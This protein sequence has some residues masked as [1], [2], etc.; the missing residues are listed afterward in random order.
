MRWYAVWRDLEGYP[1]DVVRGNARECFALL[2]ERLT[3]GAV[4]EDRALCS[5]IN[6][7]RYGLL[8]ITDQGRFVMTQSVIE[9][10]PAPDRV[11]F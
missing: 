2:R 9:R 5:P 8:V 10:S 3:E 7:T 6:R 4:L 11:P 1:V